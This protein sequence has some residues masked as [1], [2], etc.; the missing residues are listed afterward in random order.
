MPPSFEVMVFGAAGGLSALLPV[1]NH[2][3]TGPW[4]DGYDPLE[5]WEPHGPRAVR[6][7]AVEPV[8]KHPVPAGALLEPWAGIP[9]EAVPEAP[10]HTAPSGSSRKLHALRGIV[11]STPPTRMQARPW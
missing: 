10:V 2:V 8:V 7:D 11:F 3:R 6:E 5:R 4:L 1:R 9:D